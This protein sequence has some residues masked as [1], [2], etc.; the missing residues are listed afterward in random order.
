MVSS[1]SAVAGKAVPTASAVD[2]ARPPSRRFLKVVM[3]D[4]LRSLD[5]GGQR[6]FLPHPNS[7]PLLPGPTALC[8]RPLAPPI[9]CTS[10]RY[11]CHGVRQQRAPIV[12]TP[13][14]HRIEAVQVLRIAS[15]IQTV[16][17]PER[18]PP[19]HTHSQFIVADLG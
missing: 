17:R 7:A 18:H 15:E 19:R 12:A 10:G 8:R 2:S 5:V 11:L 1:T 6:R 16:S 4:P 13:L 3:T 14:R 9:G